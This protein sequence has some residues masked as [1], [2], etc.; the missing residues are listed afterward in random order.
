MGE[1]RQR[2]TRWGHFVSAAFE[3]AIDMQRQAAG[4]DKSVFVSA[5]AGSGK[6]RVLVDRVSRILLASTSP[7]KI[8]CLTYTKA[9]ASEMQERLFAALGKWS[10]IDKDDLAKTLNALEG[11]DR[12][13]S[14]EE[15][16]RARRL[17]ARALETPGGLKVQT[18]H[19]FCERLLKRFPLEA[20]L[21]PGSE[22]IDDADARALHRQVISKIQS[23]AIA[24]KD[25]EI[26]Q[27]IR[28]LA[29]AKSDADFDGLYSWAMGNAYKVDGWRNADGVT[30]LA[31][32][33]GVDP[34]LTAEVAM[35]SA[36]NDAPKV[37]IKE[38]ASEMQAGGKTDIKKADLIYA[39]FTADNDIKAYNSYAQVFFTQAG[40]PAAS[41]VT[42]KAGSVAIGL[43][44]D[45][46]AGYQAESLRMIEAAEAVKAARVLELTR[47]MYKVAVLAVNHYRGL[48]KSRRLMDF[49]DQIYLAQRL[50]TDSAAQDWV[51]YKLD[52][53]VDHILVDEAQDTSDAQWQIIDALSE[54]FFQPSPD[55]DPKAVRTLFAVGDEK[56]SIY[57]FQGAK[58]EVFLEKI[59]DLRDKQKQ[60]PE[61]R[62]SM[63]FRS[64]PQVLKLVDRV[65]FED[66]AITESFGGNFAP[67]GCHEARRDDMGIV[68]FWP[69]AK[70]PDKPEAETAWK[71]EPVDTPAAQSTREQL[72]RQI[73]I[74]IK[75][76]LETGEPV[77]DRRTCQTRPMQARDIMI[78]VTKRLPFFDGII[79]NL[80]EQGVPVAG[81]D[82]LQLSDSIAVQD[83]LS[84][85]K[86]TLLPSDDLSLAEILKSPLFGWSEQM[87][88]DVAAGRGETTLWRA[89][90]DGPD[91]TLLKRLQGLADRYAPYE[92]FARTMALVSHQGGPSLL[93]KIYN[94]I[95]IEAADALDA[96]LARALSHQ[97]RGAPSLAGFIAEI[98]R[99]ENKIKREMDT[100]QNEVRVMTV[101]AAKGLEA[102]VVILPDTTQLPSVSRERLYPVGSGFVMNVKAA[103]QPA[104]MQAIVEVCKAGVLRE[105]LR[106]LYVALTRAESRLLICGYESHNKVTEGSWHERVGASIERLEGVERMETPFGEGWRYG[107]GQSVSITD[108]EEQ[109]SKIEIPDFLKTPP[110]PL[111]LGKQRMSPSKMIADMDLEL[112]VRSPLD[113]L[114]S[115]GLGRFGRGNIIHKLLQILPDLPISDRHKTTRNYLEKQVG[116]DKEAA[117]QI[118][119]EIFAVL[120]HNDYAQFFAEG[121]QA[122]VAIAGSADDLPDDIE[123]NGQ[124]DR[125]CVQE[126]TV[127]I[128]DYKSNRPPPIDEA[129]VSEIYV[130]QMAAYRSLVRNLYPGKRIV[131]ALLWTDGPRLMRLSDARL[132]GVDWQDLPS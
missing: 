128:L 39:A 97:R 84:L 58:P 60:T 87:L 30:A 132:D 38:A 98:E 73:A 122:E 120:E 102:P 47:A 71:P 12:V 79:R 9:A 99:D 83:L 26:G 100:A 52:G 45:K 81:A 113:G 72:A 65:F 64:A 31:F 41:I 53:G 119:Q 125:L 3:Q 108:P 80:K 34:D 44:G 92:F 107:R 94:R 21:L 103:D 70:A 57:S 93:Q 131:C 75:T 5:N 67:D 10:I 19:A 82:R 69:A 77:Y 16:G 15:L 91:K 37:E 130:R 27:A 24:D 104:A 116:V 1:T 56:Q 111:A 74:Q 123:L 4:P 62:M 95:G 48:K 29:E 43:F 88:F 121:S 110:E 89:M 40:K 33:L 124:I 18:I 106:L 23:V 42:A 11:V 55:R 13:R 14:E 109:V 76:W 35:R 6:T 36:W 25:G 49:D 17:F 85:A 50:L 46:K 59:A 90:P 51:R 129:N 86:F 54:E 7:D 105:H 63:S 28:L 127:W 118:E 22:A 117:L 114:G 101:H 66:G 32:R 115:V 61:V 68:E 112:P 8:L 96:F 20:G 78:L 126:D 2:N